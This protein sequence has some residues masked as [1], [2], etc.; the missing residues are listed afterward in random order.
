MGVGVGREH[1]GEHRPGG[2]HRERVAVER[3]DL[4]VGPVDDRLHHLGGAA[5]RPARDAA[6][7]RL[8]EAHDVGL[9]AEQ[10]GGPPGSDGEAG[11]HLVE[12]EQHAVARG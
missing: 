8:G 5:D 9:H 4:L 12:R 11:L 6:A 3:A 2:G 1:L 7:E 10:R